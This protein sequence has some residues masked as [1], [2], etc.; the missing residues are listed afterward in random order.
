M[1]NDRKILKFKE[2]KEGDPIARLSSGK[3]ALP[4][5]EAEK[6]PRVGE[7]WKCR[8]LFEKENYAVVQPLTEVQRVLFDWKNGK[9]LLFPAEGEREPSSV[10]CWATKYRS[11]FYIQVESESYS[12]EETKKFPLKGEPEDLPSW[13][14]DRILERFEAFKEGEADSSERWAKRDAHDEE[15]IKLTFK[16]GKKGDLIAF[17]PS[18]KVAIPVGD[19]EPRRGE[20]WACALVEEAENYVKVLPLHEIYAVHGFDEERGVFLTEGGPAEPTSF[21]YHNEPAPHAIHKFYLT[22]ELESPHYEFSQERLRFVVRDNYEHPIEQE[23]KRLPSWAPKEIK[24]KYQLA[25]E[26]KL[27]E[28][29]KEEQRRELREEKE[30]IESKCDYAK[31]RMPESSGYSL[32]KY[33]QRFNRGVGGACPDY[34]PIPKGGQFLQEFGGGSLDEME[35]GAVFRE[36]ETPHK[37]VSV[38]PLGARGF[39]TAGFSKTQPDILDTF[40]VKACGDGEWELVENITHHLEMKGLD[41]DHAINYYPAD[42]FEAGESYLFLLGRS[43]RKEALLVTFS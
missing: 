30:R 34:C 14:P 17:L 35:E 20:R 31:V 28:R 10:T 15:V 37:E 11:D 42:A 5:R 39:Y 22:V 32:D 4:D 33:C 3:I 16:E 41:S 18:G 24:E 12:A 21:S 36:D 1:P 40:R 43:G 6:Q 38:Q 29:E 7:K 19:G 25:R 9:F 8:V 27:A 2:G 13:L 26:G 23:D